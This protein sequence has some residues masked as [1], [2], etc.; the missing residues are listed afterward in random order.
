MTRGGRAVYREDVRTRLARLR[1]DP[2]RLDWIVA[3]FLTVTVELE[4][5]LEGGA[6]HHR[7]VV[8]LLGPVMTATV[9]VRRL[10]PAAV[11]ITVA[12]LARVVAPLWGP[13]HVVS[14]RLP[15]VLA[16]YG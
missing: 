14:Y 6:A 15:R 8:A 5:W 11:G 3:A 2:L 13:P 16:V 4:A 10:Y 9:A 7:L 12:V 1:P